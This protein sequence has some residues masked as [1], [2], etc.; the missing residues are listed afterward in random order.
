[1][2][3]RQPRR[4]RHSPAVNAPLPWLARGRYPAIHW[5][6]LVF[7]FFLNHYLHCGFVVPAIE[8]VLAPCYI[9]TS[10]WHN[11]H[12]EKGQSA[13]NCLTPRPCAWMV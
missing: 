12:H 3:S 8:A 1:M 9:M 11:V 2:V 6:V 5:P 4:G 10:K 13:R 7:Y